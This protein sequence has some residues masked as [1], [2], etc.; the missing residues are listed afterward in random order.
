ME[1]PWD[2]W[3]ITHYLQAS[4]LK[5]TDMNRS[6]L[7]Y[8]AIS[9][10]C[11]IWNQP[12]LAKLTITD[13]FKT[14]SVG[15]DGLFFEDEDSYLDLAG[16]MAGDIQ[17]QF[18]PHPQKRH[19]FGFSGSTWWMKLP[20]SNSTGTAREIAFSHMYVSAD[21]IE[22]YV[23][24]QSGAIIATKR[25]GDVVENNDS[26]QRSRLVSFSAMVPPGESQFYAKILTSG[27]VIFDI[28][29]ESQA[30]H[31]NQKVEDYF[32]VSGLLGMILVMAF[33][34]LFI[35]IQLRKKTYLLFFFLA[36]S[37]LYPPLVYTGVAKYLFADFTF[38][39]NT[40]YVLSSGLCGIAVYMFTWYF[41]GLK[42]HRFL[43]RTVYL[44]LV[45][46]ALVSVASIIDY[47]TA[48][49]IAILN[50]LV[51]SLVS[52]ISGIVLSFKGDKPAFFY[53]IAWVTFTLTNGYRMVALA[54]AVP[55]NF[56]SD[57]GDIIGKVVAVSMI[58]LA[59]AEKIRLKERR[60]LDSIRSLHRNL[61]KETTKVKD[62]NEHL[63]ERVEE[64]TREI[65]SIMQHIQL[66][67]VVIKGGS[68]TV[69]NTYSE[70]IKDI[71]AVDSVDGL[72]GADLILR[73]ANLSAEAKGQVKSTLNATMEESILNFEVNESLLPQEASYTINNVQKVIQ[74]DWKP[75]VD[76]SDEVEKIIV[77]LKDVTQLKILEQDS[78]AKDRELTLI[79]EILGVSVKQFST[80]MDSAVKF[81]QDNIRLLTLN[82]NLTTDTLKIIFINLHTIKGSARTLG[83]KT[84]TPA[85]HDLEQMVA[86]FMNGKK[87]VTNEMFLAEHNNIAEQL[88]SY[89]TISSQKLGRS[90]ADSVLLTMSLVESIHRFNLDAIET[91]PPSQKLQIAAINEQL[92]N[93]TYM[94]A[95]NLF[96]EVLADA[97][98]LARDLNKEH[99]EIRITDNNIGFSSEGQTIIRNAF[100]H[101][102]R[103]SMDHGLETADERIELQKSPVGSIDLELRVVNDRLEL[104][105][106]DDGAG[107]NLTAIKTLAQ[108]KNIIDDSFKGSDL[109]LANLIFHSGFFD[110]RN[111]E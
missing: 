106:A 47:N 2:C 61:E 105:Y 11:L 15:S 31:I 108:K 64:Q 70:A 87:V 43:R 1:Y 6:T 56:F 109:D 99:P 32:L 25:G 41:L 59:L 16:V 67:I 9:L 80:F 48:A 53:T 37:F 5:E 84:L 66:G 86:D 35:Y 103:N 58:S 107:L 19:G 94:S 74:M 81:I 110:L 8:I 83:L 40:G 4:T 29:A 90:C 92:E 12:V 85:V 77:T 98:L 69:T 102:I 97:E 46:S 88:R 20:I 79:G 65:K 82:R 76:E 39:M 52:I 111:A 38:M 93:I 68:L 62:L 18:K 30:V 104:I 101:I 60:D 26:S 63:E 7:Y 42:H 45:I 22:M 3:K 44:G 78:A 89:E 55:I 73:H 14:A 91:A 23:V 10:L 54:G 17:Q 57:W 36:G 24:D 27:S 51:A 75:V 34:N 50:G 72:H 96:T 100:V 33:Y 71:L 95:Q 49:K 13:G 28:R 21:L